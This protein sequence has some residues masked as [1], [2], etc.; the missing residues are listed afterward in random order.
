[1]SG[2]RSW[3][4]VRKGYG[5]AARDERRLEIQRGIETALG[6]AELREHAGMTQAQVAERMQARQSNV[7]RLERQD[8]LYLSTLQG[9]VEALGGQLEVSAVFPEE[10]IALRPGRVA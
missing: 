5:D 3:H 1:M 6:L 10:R 9:Y 2:H 4:E 8:D 7:S